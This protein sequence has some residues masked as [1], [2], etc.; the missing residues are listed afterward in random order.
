MRAL[1]HTGGQASRAVLEADHLDGWKQGHDADRLVLLCRGHHRNRT[2]GML[3][4]EADPR[5]SPADDPVFRFYLRDGT[6]LGFAG[7]R[8]RAE[9]FAIANSPPTAKAREDAVKAIR[10]LGLGAQEAKA[11]LAAVL[12]RDPRLASGAT[13]EILRAMLKVE[14]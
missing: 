3:R 12:R 8:S 7:D 4:I 14:T 5:Q 1:L 11:R 13:E 9:G 10:A 2:K 6:F